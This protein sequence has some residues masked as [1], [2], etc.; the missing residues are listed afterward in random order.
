MNNQNQQSSLKV[1]KIY[2][3]SSKN[4]IQVI[5]ETIKAHPRYKK[6]YKVSKKYSVHC[7]DETILHKNMKVRIKPTR[8]LSKNK[9][10]CLDTVIAER[11]KK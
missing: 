1:G 9:H 8:P 4:T 3:I 10:W 11:D 6:L 5:I 2:K 7:K